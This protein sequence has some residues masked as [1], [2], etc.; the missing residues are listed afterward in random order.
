M[1]GKLA[2]LKTADGNKGV[3]FGQTTASVAV[4]GS[5]INAMVYNFGGTVLAPDGTLSI[6][7]QG[8]KDAITMLQELDK[9]GV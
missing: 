6:D 2:E 4:S 7:N 5:S 8:F 3:P 9:E 1:A